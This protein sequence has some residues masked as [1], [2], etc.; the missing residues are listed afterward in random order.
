MSKLSDKDLAQLMIKAQNG[1]ASDY[2]A[3]LTYINAFL[4]NYVRSKIRSNE[5]AEDVVQEVLI[6]IHKSRHT[7]D[8]EKSFM[9]W[10]LAIAH[11]K[12][13]DHFRNKHEKTTYALTD[14]IESQSLP[15][16]ELIINEEDRSRLIEALSEMDIR[17]QKVMSSL[18]LDGKKISEIAIEMQLTESNVKVIASRAYE[19]LRI[20]LEKHK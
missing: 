16:L 7:Y 3:L 13:A 17:S 9:S 5:R 14:D 20:K 6:S 8:A 4:S 10:L 2:E 19:T 11:F 15:V 12:M 18:K 1:E